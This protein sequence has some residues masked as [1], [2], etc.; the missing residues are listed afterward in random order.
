MHVEGQKAGHIISLDFATRLLVATA[1]L[2]D[3][4]SSEAK[5]RLDVEKKPH[6][7]R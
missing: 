4:R 5:R 1:S 3:V 6:L 7:P 2:V